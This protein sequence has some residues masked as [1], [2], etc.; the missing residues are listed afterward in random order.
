VRRVFWFGLLAAFFIAG[1]VVRVHRE[2]ADFEV[3]QRAGVR[4][5]EGAELYRPEDGHY[6]FKYLPAFALP[7]V[8]VAWL[9]D[10]VARPLW[11]GVSCVLLIFLI[12]ATVKLVPNPRL[13]FRTLVWLTVL[14]MGKFYAREL[15]LGQTNI[16]LALI[17]VGALGA[18]LSHRPLLAGALVGIGIFVKPYAVILLPLLWL[19][20][21]IAAL[22][23]ALGVAAFGL[24]LPAA[25]YGWHGNLHEL[26]GWYRTVTDTVTPN[27]FVNENVSFAATWA[28]WIGAGPLADRLTLV[29]SAIAL[30]LAGLVLWW[31]RGV[32]RAVY[33]DLG[34]LL[35]L[36]PLLSPQGWDYVLL[37]GAPAVLIACDRWRDTPRP[38]QVF[39]AVCIFLMSFTLFDVFG[40]TLYTM[41]MKVNVV[42]LAVMGLVICL[43]RLRWRKLA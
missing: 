31:R 7:M 17:L 43:M 23:V 18:L 30:G 10:P 2:L 19:E 26:R 29:T 35:L 9:P 12:R 11:Y 4:A 41:M 37:L 32:D 33:L 8:P 13:S 27:L 25:V 1:Y 14:F 16:L 22:A 3:Y 21:G 40:R 6:Q 5:A 38:W 39:T 42:T 28:K 24:V 20:A 15:N 36:V 34:L